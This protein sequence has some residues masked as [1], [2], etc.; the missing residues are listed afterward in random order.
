MFIESP[1]MKPARVNPDSCANSTAN[2]DG[3]E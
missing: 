3:A 1:R 2:D